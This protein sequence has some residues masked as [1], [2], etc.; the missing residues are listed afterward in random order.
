MWHQGDY[1]G[2][3]AGKEGFSA[4][5]GEDWKWTLNSQWWRETALEMAAG[6][7]AQREKEQ[8]GESG[9]PRC[10]RHGNC[11][12][13]LHGNSRPPASAL[14]T[15]SSRPWMVLQSGELGGSTGEA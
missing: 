3:E 13:L 7:E 12:A 5:S 11:T 15:S 6:Q 1:C 10:M 9:E 4:L 8:G 14:S 2:I